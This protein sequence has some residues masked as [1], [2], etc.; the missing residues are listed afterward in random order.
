MYITKTTSLARKHI[1]HTGRGGHLFNDKLAD[2]RRSLKVWGWGE[3]DY[4]AFQQVLQ[5]EGLTSTIVSFAKRTFWSKGTQLQ[6]R[7]H[8][9]E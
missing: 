1:K 8:V 9:T 6:Y 7:I 3:Q 4:Q 5:A 2:G